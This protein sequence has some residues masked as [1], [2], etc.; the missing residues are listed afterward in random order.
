MC[1][2][3]LGVLKLE[4]KSLQNI[5]ETKDERSLLKKKAYCFATIGFGVTLIEKKN[6]A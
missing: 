5:S 1:P 4:K 2:Q 3:L 6:G